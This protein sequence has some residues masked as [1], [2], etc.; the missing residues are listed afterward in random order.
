[1]SGAAALHAGKNIIVTSSFWPFRV[2]PL[3]TTA[4]LLMLTGCSLRGAP[5]FPLVGAYFPAWM[6]CAIIGILAAVCFRVAFLALG[7]D[8]ILRFRL[9]TY[10][11]LG[12]L[13]ALLVWALAFGP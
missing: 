10:V 2:K 5:S 4:S 3:T 12:V 7:I 6:M 1:M 11:S 8:A 13:I 9:F